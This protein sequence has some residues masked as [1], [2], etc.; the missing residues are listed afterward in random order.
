MKR[1]CLLILPAALMMLASISGC[2]DKSKPAFTRIDVSP[3]CGVVPLQVE[4]FAIATGGNE[5][6]NATGGNNNLDISWNFG[7][8]NTSSTSLTYNEFKIPGIYNVVVSAKDPD[9]NTAM[10]SIPVKVLADSLITLASSSFP[11]GETTT[12]DT[13]RFNS[14]AESCDINADNPDD[15]VKMVFRW[16]MNDSAHHVFSAPDPIFRF[17]EAGQYDVVLSVTYPAWAVTRH[18][19]LHF[20]I[21]E[22]P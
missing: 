12:A 1:L 2:N 18:D 11:T 6:G 8:G 16:E 22:A 4:C 5:S 9:G 3:D 20:T 21:S 19:T 10:R 7:D 15:Y 13:I 17:R 14:R